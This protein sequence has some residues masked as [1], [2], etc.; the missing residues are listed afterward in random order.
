MPTLHDAVHRTKLASRLKSLRPDT[1]RQW[2]MMTIDQMLWHV[3]AALGMALGRVAVPRDKL[4]LPLPIMRFLVINLPWP[5]SAPTNPSL[6]A[7]GSYDFERE[8]ETTLKLMAEI[9]QKELAS[10]WGEHPLLGRMSGPQVSKLQAKH[11]D[12]HLR[13]FGV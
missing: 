2:G 7:T 5:K 3:N 10:E 13:Q 6:I 9:G 12:H 11:I 4:P 8:R 1:A